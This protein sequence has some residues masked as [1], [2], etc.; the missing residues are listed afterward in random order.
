MQRVSENE[1]WVHE[2]IA[3]I[4]GFAVHIHILG[5]HFFCL[6]TLYLHAKMQIAIGSRFFSAKNQCVRRLLISFFVVASTGLLF[7]GP[8]AAIFFCFDAHSYGLLRIIRVPARI[9]T[10]KILQR[11]THVSNVLLLN[12]I[13]DSGRVGHLPLWVW[14]LWQILLRWRRRLGHI[15]RLHLMH[16][17]VMVIMNHF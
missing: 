13:S 4:V 8:F 10:M 6:R 7:Q 14:R 5:H 1:T 16:L 3:M 9:A 2:W 12:L 15:D 17:V 11:H